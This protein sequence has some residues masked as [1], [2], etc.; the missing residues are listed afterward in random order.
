M[1]CYNWLRLFANLNNRLQLFKTQST[2]CPCWELLFIVSRCQFNEYTTCLISSL[3]TWLQPIIII[4]FLILK[5][6]YMS[7]SSLS[8][9][10][11]ITTFLTTTHFVIK[12]EDFDSIVS[13]SQ[14]FSFTYSICEA[15]QLGPITW[16][17]WTKEV[18]GVQRAKRLVLFKM[19]TNSFSTSISS[20][21]T[22]IKK[23]NSQS[24]LSK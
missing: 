15:N 10:C 4:L 19:Q 9:C 21:C 20:S 23:F 1:L 5:Y 3:C 11:F 22:F 17:I 16:W 13:F 7:Q 18:V 8:F 24:T 6:R 2:A 14:Q 12:S